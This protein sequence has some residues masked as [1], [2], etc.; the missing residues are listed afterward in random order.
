[1]LLQRLSAMIV[2]YAKLKIE[3]TVCYVLN[4]PNRCTVH[5]EYYRDKHQVVHIS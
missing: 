4:L 5:S 1:M 2:I 3:L